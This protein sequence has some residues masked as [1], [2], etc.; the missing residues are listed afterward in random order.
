[1]NLFK[2][3]D[4]KN[5]AKEFNNG[6]KQNQ[7]NTKPEVNQAKAESNETIEKNSALVPIIGQESVEIK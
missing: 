2:N 3:D 6:N 7:E 1:M 5:S 4:K